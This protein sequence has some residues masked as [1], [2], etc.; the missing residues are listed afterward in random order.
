MATKFKKISVGTMCPTIT[1][2]TDES[3]MSNKVEL[4]DFVVDFTGAV[5]TGLD[6]GGRGGI[7]VI[8]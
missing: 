2:N 1:K 5:V 6:I 8:L 3:G 7:V 4:K